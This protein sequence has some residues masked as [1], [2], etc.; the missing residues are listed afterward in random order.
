MNQ[1]KIEVKEVLKKN[2]EVSAE[3]EKEALDFVERTFLKSNLLEPSTKDLEEVE[4]KI[5]E[6]NNEKIEEDNSDIEE[7]KEENLLENLV[8]KMER[9][10]KGIDEILDKV[11]EVLDEI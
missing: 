10:Q 7:E 2:I 5:I 4:A 6:K 3:N 11:E 1:Y 8:L 9:L